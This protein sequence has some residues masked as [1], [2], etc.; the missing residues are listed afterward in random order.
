MD[1]ETSGEI[2]GVLLIDVE[3]G[4]SCPTPAVAITEGFNDGTRTT[5]CA[6]DAD[7]RDW[8]GW[9]ATITVEGMGEDEQCLVSWVSQSNLTDTLLKTTYTYAQGITK[10]GTTTFTSIYRANAGGTYNVQATVSAN[11]KAPLLL[12]NEVLNRTASYSVDNVNKVINFT[13]K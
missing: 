1:V 12:G 6:D 10:E 13:L 4:E 8:E 7:F 9:T 11:T 3:A 2:Y 5:Y